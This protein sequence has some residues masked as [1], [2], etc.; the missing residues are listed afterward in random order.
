M[1][2]EHILAIS[3]ISITLCSLILIA[4]IIRRAR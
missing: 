4:L 2:A 1:T 3:R